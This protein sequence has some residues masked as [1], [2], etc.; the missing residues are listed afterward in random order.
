[1]ARKL[2]KY[3]KLIKDKARKAGKALKVESPAQ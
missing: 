2:K 1:M 3:P